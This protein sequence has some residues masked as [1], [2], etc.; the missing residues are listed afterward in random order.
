M[1]IKIKNKIT[2]YEVLKNKSD[3]AEAT[4]GIMDN[5]QNPSHAFKKAIEASESY[6]L[7]YYSPTDYNK[8]GKFKSIKVRVINQDYKIMYRQGYFA[9]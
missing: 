8:D 3:V 4:G 7:L 2:G 5:S 1:T 6:Y 9:N